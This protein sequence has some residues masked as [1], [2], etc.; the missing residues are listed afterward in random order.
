MFHI[1]SRSQFL[2]WLVEHAPNKVVQQA[3]NQGKITVHGLFKGGWVV[4]TEY[5]GTSYIVGIKP[6]GVDRR[7]VCGL[8]SH[9]PVEDYVGGESE[10]A[11]GD[12]DG[13]L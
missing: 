5:H 11:K 1:T 3:L 8:L 7:L 2:D 13:K 4:E 9:V 6:I 10:L 12:G